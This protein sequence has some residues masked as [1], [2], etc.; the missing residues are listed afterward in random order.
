[1]DS[2]FD[3]LPV[4]E[5][6]AVPGQDLAGGAEPGGDV[7]GGTFLT[8]DD[9]VH[10]GPAARLLSLG[11]ERSLALFPVAAGETVRRE[12]PDR[13]AGPDEDAAA[14]LGQDQSFGLE[15]LD[16]VPHGHPGDAVVLDHHGLG[17]DLLVLGQAA[18]L[19]GVP[20]VVGDLPEDRTVASRVECAENSS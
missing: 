15:D 12:P 18:L 11:D 19:D 4:E 8:D 5:V 10:L 9:A 17:G 16:G 14:V 2:S 20:Q 3:G 13:G 6:A 7:T 1:G